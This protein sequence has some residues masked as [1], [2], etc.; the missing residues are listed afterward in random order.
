MRYLTAGFREQ[1][2]DEVMVGLGML[3][4][5]SVIVS[6]QFFDETE[7]RKYLTLRRTY[8]ETF[9]KACEGL[10]EDLSSS[11]DIELSKITS[12]LLK[13][14]AQI[15]AT[16]AQRALRLTTRVLRPLKKDVF[17]SDVSPKLRRLV[18]L[19]V[20]LSVSDEVENTKPMMVEFVTNLTRYP[21]VPAPVRTL[22]R[23]ALKFINHTT[24]SGTAN[25]GAWFEM[26]SEQKANIRSEMQDLLEKQKS[27]YQT[28]EDPEK[29]RSEYLRI[30]KKLNRLQNVAGVNPTIINKVVE[31]ASLEEVLKKES[32]LQVDGPTEFV[33]NEVVK[34]LKDNYEREGKLS[35]EHGKLLTQLKKAKTLETVKRVVSEAVGRKLLYSDS[36]EDIEKIWGKVAK[37]LAVKKGVKLTPIEWKPIDEKTFQEKHSTGKVMFDPDMPQDKRVETLGRVS[38]ALEDLE[39]IFGKGFSG[40]HEKSLD[41]DFRGTLNGST[42]N[43]FA[44]AN[45]NN[46]QPKV[47][48]G[49]DYPGYLAHE[50][51][52]FFEDL[53]ASKLEKDTNPEGYEKTKQKVGP[54][55]YDLFGRGTVDL[56]N[57][58]PYLKNKDTFPE[59]LEFAEAVV[60]TPDFKRWKDMTGNL[61]HDK[62]SQAI[63]NLTGSKVF[64]LEKEHPYYKLYYNVPKYKSD[65]PPELLVETERVYLSQGGDS[66]KL[67]YYN[68]GT[69]IWA[70]MVEQYVATKLAEVGVSN[71][72]L[73]QISYDVE[74]LPQMMDQDRFEKVVSPILDRLFRR[75]KDR[76]LIAKQIKSRY[77]STLRGE[78]K[79]FG[80]RPK[81]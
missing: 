6:N 45:S 73:T 74:D 24:V 44:W 47:T 65:W 23:K 18:F 12:S 33:Q 75:I 70:R 4:S 25:V 7:I 11:S 64:E 63:F 32:K 40:K 31:E 61:H 53:L 55:S 30:Q 57:Y 71:P 17:K 15:P 54:G 69:E 8:H 66:R 72:W 19:A 43:Y 38:R 34:Y 79:A 5:Q 42:A 13:Q 56:E 2:L 52:H 37:N 77:C 21:A 58:L 26:T 46:W 68:S 50:L 67:N 16:Q 59:V 1:Y 14:I 80:Q 60:N 35:R 78:Q 51:S 27:V 49:D 3:L 10:A 28:Y 36:L 81:H 20:Q 41:F 29:R 39:G 9:T 48:F 76:K 22:L 62:V